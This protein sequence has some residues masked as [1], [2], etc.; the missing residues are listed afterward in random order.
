MPIPPFLIGLIIGLG[1]SLWKQYQFNRE[2]NQILSSLSQFEQVKSLSTVS[3]IRRTVNLFNR[4]F[5]NLKSQ[6]ETHQYLLENIPI[7]YLEID[8]ENQLVSCNKKARRLLKIER[9]QPNNLRL[10]L[11]LVIS[12]ELDRLIQQTR[13]TQQPLTLKWDFY[14]NENSL[15]DQKEDKLKKQNTYPLFLKAY[16]YPLPH[17][18]IV[19]FVKNKQKIKE[20]IDSKNRIF[21]DLSHEL[22]T[23]LTST[24]LLTEMLLKK[25]HTQEK[26]LIE[27]MNKEIHR[28]IDLV[29]NWLDIA[30]I[31]D[32]PYQN[33]QYQKLDLKQLIVSAWESLE[34]LALQKN[35]NFLYQGKDNTA[36]EADLNRLTQVFI[37]LFDNSIKNT[38]EN[39]QI[40]VNV[41]L[42]NSNIEINIIDSGMGFNSQDLPHIFERLYRGDKSRVRESRQGSGLGLAIVKEIIEAH[43]GLITAQNHPQTGSAWLKIVLPQLSTNY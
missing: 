5:E 36:V 21:S 39:G 10:F 37:N 34:P 26:K 8:E 18:K 38:D 28:L 41:Q 11:E 9:W 13:K 4:E 15:E 27:Q 33:L 23:P 14:P 19:V 22:R 2:I 29:Q 12:F 43:N 7:G 31:E 30:Q 24:S 32:N 6:I 40:Q 3:L 1:I 17:G 35:I 25:I 42:V 16:S 20:L